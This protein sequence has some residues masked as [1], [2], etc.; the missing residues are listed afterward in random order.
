VSVNRRQRVVVTPRID[1]RWA[2][3]A[4]AANI[5]DGNL[6]TEIQINNESAIYGHWVELDFNVAVPLTNLAIR[7]R[8]GGA[9]CGALRWLTSSG[10]VVTSAAQSPS[11]DFNV[12]FNGSAVIWVRGCFTSSNTGFDGFGEIT[13]TYASASVRGLM[14]RILGAVRP[15]APYGRTTLRTDV[16]SVTPSIDTTWTTGNLA[17]LLDANNSTEI[18]ANNQTVTGHWIQLD[19]SPP[20]RLLVLTLFARGGSA[21]AGPCT[22]TTSDSQS[23]TSGSMLPSTDAVVTFT[24]APISWLRGTFT[25]S[26]T[27]FDGWGELWCMGP[28][29]AVSYQG[30]YSR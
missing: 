15:N 13:P 29:A 1:T 22:W 26:R 18:Q 23:Q 28:S 21:G 3:T 17:N 30:G 9:G 20:M 6:G 2:A 4:N 7:A 10:Q 25:G 12:A 5:T 14:L 8:G 27:N 16:T 11:V 24:G 19:F